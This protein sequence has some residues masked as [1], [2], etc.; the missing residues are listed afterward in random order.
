[1]RKRMRDLHVLLFNPKNIAMAIIII[2]SGTPT[3]IAII[4]ISL[5]FE[6]G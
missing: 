5:F 4:I 1:M 6:E 2:K 3:A